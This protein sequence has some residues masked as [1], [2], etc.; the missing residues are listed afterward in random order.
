M[1][2]ESLDETIDRVAA[3]MAAPPRVNVVVAVRDQITRRRP[4]PLSGPAILTA[5]GVV[6]VVAIAAWMARPL[7]PEAVAG[8]ARELPARMND[9]VAPLATRV[10]AARPILAG[11]ISE[12]VDSDAKA[13]LAIEPI[14]IAPLVSES[15]AEVAPLAV[16][17]ILMREIPGDDSKEPR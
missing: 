10:A 1:I 11:P 15:L 3:A 2:R 7:P 8:T 9:L 14:T 6:A 12:R 4:V 5:A 16:N 13:S 17:D